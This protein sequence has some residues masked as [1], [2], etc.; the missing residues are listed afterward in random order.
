METVGTFLSQRRTQG[1][2]RS[3][4]PSTQRCRGRIQYQDRWYLDLSSNDYLGLADDAHLKQASTAAIEQYGTGSGAAR[5]LSGDSALIHELETRTAVLKGKPAALVFNSGYQ[6]NV[7]I[8][9]A[10]CARGDAVLCDRLSH[11]SILDG[12][13]LSGARLFRFRHNDVE[14]LESLL[15]KTAGRFRRRLVVTESLFSMDGDMAPLPALVAATQSH[16]VMV[17]VDEA[18]ATG[19]YGPGGSGLVAE[20]GVTEQVDLVMGT[21]SKG[22][23]GFGGYVA[24]AQEM[25]D[26]FVNSAR[27]FIYST[28]L[29]PGVVAG[30]LAALDVLA[31]QPERRMELL[32][33]AAWLREKLTQRGLTT[34]GNSQIIPWMVGRAALACQRSEQLQSRGF[35]VLPVRPPT[36][37]AGQARLRLSVTCAHTRED[38]EGLLAAI[39]EVRDV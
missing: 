25:K 14:H 6:A 2:L 20:Q 7:G 35:W 31:Q 18:H 33:R 1:L 29:P 32:I 5:L 23:G 13:A 39:D 22:L 16:E 37:P 21:Y 19:L 38:L 8:I 4:H 34:R 24:C 36:V 15:V 17:L 12:V 3:L 26:Y 28:A 10:L 11:A 30:N 27:S 9:S